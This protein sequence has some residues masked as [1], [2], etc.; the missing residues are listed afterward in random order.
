MVTVTNYHVRQRRDGTNFIVLTL[1]GGLEMVQSQ[2]SGAWKAM[3]RKCQIPSN[4]D[5]PT[6]KLVIGTQMPGNIVRVQSDP[7]EYTDKQTGETI[8]LSHSYSFQP[9]GATAVVAPQME[10]ALV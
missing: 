10:E 8:T 2:S 3:V 5:E 7:Y 4:L 6:A 9:E 1:S